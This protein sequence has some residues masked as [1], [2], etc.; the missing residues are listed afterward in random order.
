MEA[1]LRHHWRYYS[2]LAGQRKEIQ[3][4]LL[5]ALAESATGPIKLEKWQRAVRFKYSLHPLCVVGSLQSFVGGRFN[6]SENLNPMLF[7][8][9]PA[10]YAAY[11]R[12]TAE[13]EILCQGNRIA[14]LSNQDFALAKK[15]SITIVAVDIYLEKCLDTRKAGSLRRF[16][17]LIKDFKI[18]PQLKEEARK[19]DLAEPG[20]VKLPKELQETLLAPDW[21]TFPAQF[22]IPANPQIIGQ[23]VYEAGIEGIIYPSRMT[24]RDAVAV[25]TRNFGNGESWVE[26]SDECPPNTVLKRIA[27]SNYLLAEK[28]QDE[29]SS[30]Q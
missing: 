13:Q 18:P 29:L 21:R 11:D 14:G 24:G 4:D 26:I 17:N 16:T 2:E 20:A 10:L 6:I 22:D 1:I 15:D 27:A 19:L 9:F 25:F 12:E 5:D 3:S 23:L 8:P 30:L 7:P 28:T